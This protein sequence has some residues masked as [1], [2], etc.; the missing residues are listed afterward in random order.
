MN[1]SSMF[2]HI[3][4]QFLL[5]LLCDSRFLSSSSSRRP[6]ISRSSMNLRKTACF[7]KVTPSKDF[8]SMDQYREAV[9]NILKL[10]NL[11][12]EKLGGKELLSIIIK[13]W[14]VPYDLQLRKADVFGEASRNIYVNVMWKYYGQKSYGKTEQEY[15]ENLE[16]I[17]QY[18]TKLGKV[19]DF[20]EKV[21]TIFL[22]E[23]LLS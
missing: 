6:M 19:T 23:W 12:D 18:I 10:Q 17:G 9:V 7:A 8:D 4:I 1:S 14:G 11:S 20:K 5:L 15:M 16:A 3:F 2:L 13:K 22:L 21:I